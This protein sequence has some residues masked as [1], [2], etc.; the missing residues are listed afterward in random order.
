MIK[1]NRGGRIIGTCSLLEKPNRNTL[2]TNK[3]AIRGLTQIAACEWAK[4]GIT[5]N[6]YAPGV[7]DT[8]LL[9][10]MDARL[11]DLLHAGPGAYV[12]IMK[13]QMS[14]GR[15][16]QPEEVARVVS[17]LASEEAAI[18]TGQTLIVDTPFQMLAI[19][20]R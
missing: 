12:E 9:L 10:Q 15:V 18:V 5:V 16:A 1:Q 7:T 20:I 2:G 17:F 4:Y 6:G 11:A 3:V 19:M 8:P 13:A 14:F